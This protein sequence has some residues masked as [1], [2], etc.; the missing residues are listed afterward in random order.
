MIII[1][2]I[3][4]MY[5]RIAIVACEYYKLCHFKTCKLR[6]LEIIV[7]QVFSHT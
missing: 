4:Y 7:T 5:I 2:V 1:G 6:A 3:K